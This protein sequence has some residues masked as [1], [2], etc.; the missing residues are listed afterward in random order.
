MAA[1]APALAVEVGYIVSIN[2]KLVPPTQGSGAARLGAKE[3]AESKQNDEERPL[4]SFGEGAHL[5]MIFL[6]EGD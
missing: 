6:A 5:P 4:A 3:S 1:V 2:K